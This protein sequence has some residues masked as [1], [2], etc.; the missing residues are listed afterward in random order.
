MSIALNSFISIDY[1]NPHHVSRETEAFLADLTVLVKHAPPDAEVTA[2]LHPW[3]GKPETR[4]RAARLRVAMRPTK[5]VGEPEDYIQRLLTARVKADSFDPDCIQIMEDQL[6][7]APDDF[8]WENFMGRLLTAEQKNR[9]RSKLARVI[10]RGNRNPYLK[11]ADYHLTRGDLPA[12]GTKGDLSG[13]LENDARLSLALILYLQGDR[14]EA[15]A[16]CRESIAHAARWGDTWAETEGW[17]LLGQ[18]QRVIGGEPGAGSCLQRARHLIDGFPLHSLR[19]KAW[20]LEGLL[21]VDHRDMDQAADAFRKIIPPGLRPAE[22]IVA[23]SALNNLGYIYDERG[24]FRRALRCYD[25]VLPFFGRTRDRRSL[26]MTLLNRGALWEKMNVLDR[27]RQDYRQLLE[28]EGIEQE[29]DLRLMALGNLGNILAREEDYDAA[30]SLLRE[31]FLLAEQAGDSDEM[32]LKGS[33]LIL[34]YLLQD[35]LERAA[36]LIG[37]CE[38]IPVTDRRT[39]GSLLLRWMKARY[40]LARDD[41]PSARRQLSPLA[42]EFR[43]AGADY[44]LWDLLYMEGILLEREGRWDE[45]LE[46][47]RQSLHRIERIQDACE[48]PFYQL[49]YLTN[50]RDVLERSL[51]LLT[52]ALHDPPRSAGLALDLMDRY[53]CRVLRQQLPNQQRGGVN[54]ANEVNLENIQRFLRHRNAAA[55]VFFEGARDV[56][57][58]ALDDRDI[59]FGILA[60]RQELTDGVA[61]WLNC[62]ANADGSGTGQTGHGITRRLVHPDMQRVAKGCAELMIMPDGFLHQVPFDLL[63]LAENRQWGTLFSKGKRLFFLPSWEFALTHSL[64]E[65]GAMEQGGYLGIYGEEY[66]GHGLDRLSWSRWEVEIG[67]SAFPW[68]TAAL[69]AGKEFSTNERLHE[70]HR[71]QWTMIHIAAHVEANQSRPWEGAVIL[72]ENDARRVVQG[73]EELERL[74]WQAEL[75]LLSGCSTMQGRSYAGEG[76]LNVARSVLVSGSRSVLG[77]LWA[78]NDR[79]AYQFMVYFYEGLNHANGRTGE[80]LRYAKERMLATPEFHDPLYWSGYVLYGAPLA[81]DLPSPAEPSLLQEGWILLPLGLAAGMG[82]LHIFRRRIRR[83]I[84]MKPSS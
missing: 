7:R 51:N 46:C 32:L 43:Q 28:V 25:R 37:T 16:V 49:H 65:A 84:R 17:L 10:G 71:R 53:R 83:A 75:V 3:L 39:L 36:E 13:L 9:I 35:R 64:K 20:F 77:T 31:A 58:L 62:L 15:A 14:S 54:E 70:L 40:S 23:A 1:A 6:D 48:E 50:C 2:R 72:H 44:A 74:P 42:E 79:A 38:R 66:A 81:I 29:P 30:E 27:A 80:A 19:Q 60:P 5:A 12:F 18:F 67:A 73:T 45:A 22:T 76:I 57:Y 8:F 78:V 52:G 26:A 69:V 82:I 56:Y 34:L 4:L 63:E 68:T 55:W 21:A 41:L 33:N 61:I 59:H 24:E 47:Y 11:V